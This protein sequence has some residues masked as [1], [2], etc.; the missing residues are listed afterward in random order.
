[1]KTSRCF[2]IHSRPNAQYAALDTHILKHMRSLGYDTPKSTPSKKQ[3]LHLEKEF[4]KLAKKADMSPA[5]YD[6]MIWNKYSK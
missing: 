2:I 5:N 1:M 4:L 3:Y 6:L